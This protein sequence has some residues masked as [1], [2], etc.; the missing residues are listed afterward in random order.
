LVVT[1]ARLAAI[2]GLST[3]VRAVSLLPSTH[4]LIAGPD[5]ADGTLE[6][7]HDVADRLGVR[8]RV[9][10]EPRGLWGAD[11]AAALA[12]ADAF[13]LP[14]SYESFG[15]SAAEAAGVGIPVVLTEG[16][17]VKDMLQCAV[18][19]PVDDVEA[20]STALQAAV[21]EGRKAVAEAARVRERLNWASIAERQESVYETLI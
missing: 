7:I 9:R 2:K 21:G 6:T 3:L 15:T 10:V 11:K 18:V 8:D 5:E 20:L 13:C 16:C 4:L 1:L 14:S 17:G 19:V 12:E